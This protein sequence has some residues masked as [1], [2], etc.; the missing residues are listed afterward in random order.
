MR[1][2]GSLELL[3]NLWELA[4]VIHDDLGTVL[5]EHVA[6]LLGLGGVVVASDVGD[7]GDASADS[8]EGSGLAVLDGN[9][10]FGLDPDLLASEE[11]DGWVGFGG[12]LRKRGGGRED[13]TIREVFGLVDLLNGSNNSAKSRRRDDGH[14]VLALLVEPVQLLIGTLAWLCLLL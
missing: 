11:V 7:S 3:E 13:V 5:D 12:W 8:G 4:P 10:L 2:L 1:C 6:D 14:A 9:A